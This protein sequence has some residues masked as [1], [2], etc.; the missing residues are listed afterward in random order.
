MNTTSALLAEVAIM[1]VGRVLMHEKKL[2]SRVV[3]AW[4]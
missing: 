1:V 3:L 2:R 4:I